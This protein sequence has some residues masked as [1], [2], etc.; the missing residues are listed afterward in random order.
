ML[1]SSFS[2]TEV[3]GHAGSTVFDLE[4]SFVWKATFYFTLL[5]DFRLLLLDIL[6]FESLWLN[7]E[8]F[9]CFSVK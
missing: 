5:E 3:R 1:K 9:C 6:V 8:L 2:R 7:F 4:E